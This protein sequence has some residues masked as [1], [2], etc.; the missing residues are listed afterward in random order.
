MHVSIRF[1]EF[2]RIRRF[3]GKNLEVNKVTRLYES[4]GKTV[5][6]YRPEVNKHLAAGTDPSTLMLDTDGIEILEVT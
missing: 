4:G 3:S 1:H 5:L 6:W 2:K